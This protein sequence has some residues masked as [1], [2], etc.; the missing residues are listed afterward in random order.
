MN[1]VHSNI[2]SF[3]FNLTLNKTNIRNANFTF[4]FS[5][6]HKKAVFFELMVV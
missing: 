2:I 1:E 6:E 4:R 3:K 5:I